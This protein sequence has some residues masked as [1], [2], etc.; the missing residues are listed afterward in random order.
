MK[1]GPF[2]TEGEEK[3]G[4]RR[5]RMTDEIDIIIGSKL[6]TAQPDEFVKYG[7]KK[8]R[9]IYLHK[10]TGK[11]FIANEA[12]PG[13]RVPPYI[14]G[15]TIGLF[16][17]GL[18]YRDI[19]RRI[20]ERHGFKP[21]TATLYEW[22]RDYVRRGRQFLSGLKARTGDTWAA[23]EM[24]TRID[25]KQIWVWSVIDTKTRYLLATHISTTRTIPD[26]VACSARL[27][28]GLPL[29]PSG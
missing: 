6:P 2:C 10:P 9:Q 20:D 5:K 23:D 3:T 14:V 21:S 13:R 24:M 17:D 8:G 7:F 12:L 28:S 15:D 18:S 29:P 22:V 11:R 16:Y 26:A 19:Q 1:V 27:L 25:G 4:N